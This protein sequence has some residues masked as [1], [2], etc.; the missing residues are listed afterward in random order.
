[1]ENGQSSNYPP[2]ADYTKCTT[3]KK[4]GKERNLRGKK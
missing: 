3:E 2:N 4:K 1:V